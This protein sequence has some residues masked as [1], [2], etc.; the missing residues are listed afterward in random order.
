[1]RGA[2]FGAA[3]DKDVQVDNRTAPEGRVGYFGQE[4]ASGSMLWNDTSDNTVHNGMGYI[5]AQN[6]ESRDETRGS[7]LP[8]KI[9][10]VSG[11]TEDVE[12][13]DLILY[14]GKYGVIENCVMTKDSLNL[15]SPGRAYI[16]FLNIEDACS[17]VSVPQHFIYGKPC[18]VRYCSLQDV[19]PASSETNRVFVARIPAGVTQPEFR[20]YFGAFG[21]IKDAYMPKDSSKMGHRGIGFITYAHASSVE[22]VM[23]CKHALGGNELAIDRANPKDKPSGGMAPSRSASSQP[24]LAMAGSWNNYID[25]SNRT[26]SPADSAFSTP[27]GSL[28]DAFLSRSGQSLAS[29]HSLGSPYYSGR[30]QH[31][32]RSSSNLGLPLPNVA[33]NPYLMGGGF[34]QS[35]TTQSMTNMM[36]P[37]SPAGASYVS[38][39]SSSLNESASLL[40]GRFDASHHGS[41]GESLWLQGGSGH[42]ASMHGPMSARAGPRLFVGKLARETTEMDLKNYF[43]QFGFVL[44][45]YLPRDKTNKQEHRGFGFVTFETDA[46]IH[47]IQGIGNHTILGANIAIESAVPRTSVDETRVEPESDGPRVE[48]STAETAQLNS[49]FEAFGLESA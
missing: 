25:I 23:M 49:G 10:L 1:M 19:Q 46:A 42:G 22:R 6:I 15:E 12:R 48:L 2:N 38:S 21:T 13:D 41:R 44:D 47:R 18:V 7:S 33:S 30:S 31:M 28:A 24:N 45:V 17:A 32:M 40:S 14:F 36:D 37:L 26:T 39:Y 29:Q 3:L 34:T 27:Q 20:A 4:A 11:L 35:P 43:S 16:T 9:I 8:S 5:R